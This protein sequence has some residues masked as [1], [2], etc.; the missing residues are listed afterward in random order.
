MASKTQ[1]QKID[2]SRNPLA[3]TTLLE[4]NSEGKDFIPEPPLLIEKISNWANQLLI[5]FSLSGKFLAFLGPYLTAKTHSGKV[6]N[7]F[8]SY[9]ITMPSAFE[10]HALDLSF[11]DKL[12]PVFLSTPPTQSKV[13]SQRIK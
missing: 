1:T 12:A 9:P 10:E 7:F 5:P 6:K 4:E 13:K 11:M 8:P 2:T 3:F